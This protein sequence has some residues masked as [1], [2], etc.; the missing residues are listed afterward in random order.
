MSDKSSADEKRQLWQLR[1]DEW[2]QSRLSVAQWS[3]EQG[4][5]Y[6][7][8]IYWKDRILGKELATG[9]VELP[10]TRPKEEIR[11]EMQGVNLY[12]P[13]DLSKESLKRALQAI[14]AV[15]C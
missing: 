15:A 2:K 14:A 1:I 6:A 12:L 4:L 8:C 10:E 13:L 5:S 9:F 11:V 3:K 7:Q